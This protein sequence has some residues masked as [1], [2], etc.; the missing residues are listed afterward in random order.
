MVELV[1]WTKARV[2]REEE[3]SV[4]EFL[5]SDWLIGKHEAHSLD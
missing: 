5:L 3:L 2:V 1:N 4:E